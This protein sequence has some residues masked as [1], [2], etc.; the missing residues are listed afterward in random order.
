MCRRERKIPCVLKKNNKVCC[1]ITFF[2]ID[3]EKI[4]HGRINS[5][6]NDAIRDINGYGD[7]KIR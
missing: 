2:R 4:N 7:Q 6:E 5:A 3:S 1:Q